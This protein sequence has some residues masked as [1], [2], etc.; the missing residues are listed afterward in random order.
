MFFL[1]HRFAFCCFSELKQLTLRP[2]EQ[3]SQC[4]DGSEEKGGRDTTHHLGGLSI[5]LKYS[6]FWRQIISGD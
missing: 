3:R 5:E 1:R 6:R 2:R 4:D